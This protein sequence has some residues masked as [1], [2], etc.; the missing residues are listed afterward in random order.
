MVW[1]SGSVR[2]LI[3]FNRRGVLLLIKDQHCF[4]S[5]TR[6]IITVSRKQKTLTLFLTNELPCQ[7][8]RVLHPEDA[9]ASKKLERTRKDERQLVQLIRKICCHS[10]STHLGTTQSTNS[11]SLKDTSAMLFDG[12]THSTDWGV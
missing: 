5:G 6:N 2:W 8:F 4:I 10:F 7:M 1:C 11:V 3:A 9:A 12:W